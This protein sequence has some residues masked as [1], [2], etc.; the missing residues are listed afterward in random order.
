MLSA[1]SAAVRCTLR[2]PALGWTQ[3]ARW[4]LGATLGLVTASFLIVVGDAAAINVPSLPNP[5]F[6]QGPPCS[7]LPATAICGWNGLVG[8]MTQDT[9]H[10]TGSFSMKLNNA[11]GTSVEATTVNGVCV[12][13][14]T[15]GPH[16]ASFW[17][18]TASPVVDVQF[19][20]N[21]YPNTT[22][23]VATF[24][25]DALH[26]P[27]PIAYGAWTHVTGTLTAPPGTGSAFFSF[28]ASC[29]C[30]T[31]SVITA[32]F[33]DVAVD[34][35]ATGVTLRSLSASRTTAG[36]RLRWR[37]GSEADAV[38]FHVYRA[39]ASKLARVDGRLIPARGSV[40]GARY[41]F[42]DR[43]A[44]AAGLTYRLQ[45]VG[46]DGSRTW[47]GRVSVVP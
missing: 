45:T 28:F 10:N 7:P 44:P 13:P 16:S 12:S 24:G 32:Y 43:R 36:V 22:C 18:M 26:A 25:N 4:R 17:Y 39:R 23:T 3:M 1:G 37:T 30:S 41:T 20:G 34:T 2:P 5:T 38:G 29:Q 21:W 6:E 47:S 27:T 31:P 42:V 40:S 35:G 33:D 19:G 8:T 46:T 15:A 9:I 14:I 11:S